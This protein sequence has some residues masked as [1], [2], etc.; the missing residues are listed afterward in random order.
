M[1]IVSPFGR[2]LLATTMLTSVL[3]LPAAAVVYNGVAAGDMSTNDAILWTRADNGGNPTALTAQVATDSGFTN[4]VG[5]FG[6]TTTASA[7]YTLKVDATGLAANTQYYYRYTDGTTTSQAGAFTTATP[8][9]QAVPVKFAFSGDADGRFRPYT[10]MNG[11]GTASQVQTQGLKF[12]SFLGDTM[13]ETASANSP[14]VPV[15]TSSTSGAALDTGLAAYQRKYREN[16]Q[17]V[18]GPTTTTSPLT[19]P[20]AGAANQ[21]SGQQSLQNMLAATGTYTVLDNHEL[22]NQSLQSGG[23]PLAAGSRVT[24]AQGFDVNTTGAYDNQA[25]GFKTVLKAYLDYH[26]TK[27]GLTGTPSTGLT[28]TATSTVVNAPADT[29]SNGTLQQ[30]FA[31]Q[32]GKNAVYIQLDDRTYRDSRLGVVVNGSTVDDV[33]SGR[34]NNQGRTMLGST[35]LAWIKQQLLAQQ[36]SGTVWKFIAVSTP[37]DQTGPVQDGKS[38]YG[39]YAAERND[40]M[41]FIADNHISNVVFLTTDDHLTRMNA[42]TYQTTFGDPST[43]AVVPGA[44]QVVTGPIGAGGPDAITDHSFANLQA[45]LG[46]TQSGL[47]AFNEPQIGLCAFTGVSNTHRQLDPASGSGCSPVDFFSPDTFNYTTLDVSADGSSLTI[48]TWGIPSYQQN[49]FPQDN[50]TV[51]NVLGF[52]IQSGF[53]AAVPEPASLALLATGIAALAGLRRRRRG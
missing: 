50:P 39:G 8:V 25:A 18:V 46:L 14:A 23:A 37:I 36:A 26:P 31:Q 52:T 32:Q 47:Q 5:S 33:T 30:Y 28:P 53:I 21:T 41:K 29:R 35:Q 19:P 20:N 13:Y 11:F 17:G 42:L 24:A 38:W 7:D 2:G 48:N 40:I 43:T 4:V 51:S 44:F 49:T 27:D 15:L 12:F 6:G 9:T 1:S 3:A 34:Q 16:V 22:G 10:V 45:L